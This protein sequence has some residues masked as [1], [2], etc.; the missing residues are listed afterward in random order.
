MK[1]SRRKKNKTEDVDVDAEDDGIEDDDDLVSTALLLSAP[2]LSPTVMSISALVMELKGHNVGSRDD[3]D[4]REQKG[5]SRDVGDDL[6]SLPLLLSAPP[7]SPIVTT[8]T[9]MKQKEHDDRPPI[10]TPIVDD[11]VDAYV[12]H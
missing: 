4:D 2:P 11:V 8:A 3:D 9:A 7:L 5:G 6:L 10:Y 12:V 1:K